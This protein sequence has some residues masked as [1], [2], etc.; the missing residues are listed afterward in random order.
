MPDHQY[1]QPPSDYK[2]Q[3]DGSEHL[4]INN[5]WFRRFWTLLA[6]H[7]TGKFYYYYSRHKDNGNG[8]CIIQISKSR[9]VKTGRRIHLTE[10][11]T[12]KYV[13]DNTT[14]IPVPKVYCSFLHRKQAYIVM[15]RIQGGEELPRAWGAMSQEARDAVLLQLRRMISELRGLAASPPGVATGVQSCV[16]GSLY[17]ARLSGR[18]NPRWGPFKTIQDFHV[19]LRR[20]YSP[21]D[22]RRDRRGTHLKD[23]DAS[24]IEDMISRQDRDG[25]WASPVFTHCDLNPSNIL[26]RDGKV[27]GIIDWE[28][29]GWYPPYW[30]YTSAWFGNIIRPWW[31]AQLDHFLDRP[32]A[33]DFKMEQVR[34]TWW[35]EW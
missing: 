21:E 1:I 22:L 14:G 16:G 28:F 18:G 13:A 15:E 27:V 35:G 2:A 10:G 29:S 8:P 12:M 33:E 20:D 32:C 26:V 4:A 3:H 30:E 34:N 9:I 24:D 23:Q 7:T 31:Q 6:V 25:Q 5:T 19:W 11:A 17:D